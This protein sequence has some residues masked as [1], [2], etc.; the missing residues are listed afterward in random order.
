MKNLEIDIETYSSIDLSKCGVYKYA[1]AEDFE[2]LL[3][4]YSVDGGEGSGYTDPFEAKEFVAKTKVYSLAVAIGTA[5]GVYRGEPNL[6]LDRLERIRNEV[7]IPLVLHGASGLADEVVIESIKRGICKVNFAT[8]L[9]IAFSNGVKET[10]KENPEVI[11]PKKFGALG[12]DYVKA[13]VMEKM[14]VCGCIYR[15]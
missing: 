14:K 5:H 15:V 3:F 1:E 12:R 7:D 10:L 4:G 2:I 13:I 11:D 6:D 8:E 9:R